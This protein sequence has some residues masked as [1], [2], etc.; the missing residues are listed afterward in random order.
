[1]PFPPDGPVAKLSHGMGGHNALL[2]LSAIAM[3]DSRRIVGISE[4]WPAP[5][6]MDSVDFLI[7]QFGSIFSSSDHAASRV[8]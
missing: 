2:V 5:A 1:M 7:N 3:S 6:I 4:T 8:F